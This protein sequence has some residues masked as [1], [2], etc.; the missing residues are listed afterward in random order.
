MN[1]L[2]QVWQRTESAWDEL[3]QARAQKSLRVQAE[4]DILSLQDEVAKEAEKVEAA[5][6]KSKENKD[7]KT[8]RTASLAKDLKQKELENACKLYEEFFEESAS[9]FLDN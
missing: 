5:I 4:A 7:W 2:Q 9:K 8:I 6:T 1:I 3:K